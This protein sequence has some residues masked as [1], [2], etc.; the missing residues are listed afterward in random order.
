MVCCF[1]EE[2]ITPNTLAN[3]RMVMTT[4]LK[5]YAHTVLRYTE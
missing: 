5:A 4:R 1:M 3:M 2:V